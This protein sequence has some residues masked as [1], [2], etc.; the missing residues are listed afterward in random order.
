MDL[1]DLRIFRA[2]GESGSFT[3][4]AQ[5]LY[6]AQP[7]VSHRMAELEAEVGV[8]LFARGGRGTHLTPAGSLLMRHVCDGLD[9]IDR[10]QEALGQYVAGK[11]G[12]VTL[13]SATTAATY[14]LPAIL[15]RYLREHPAID[16]KV[17]TGRSREVLGLMSERQVDIALVRREVEMDGTVGEIVRSEPL[18]LVAAHGHRLTR[19]AEISPTDLR[20]QPLL[21]Y[22]RRS[23]FWAGAYAALS[24]QGASMHSAM[25][26]DSIEAVKAMCQAGLGLALLPQST[27]QQDLASGV[28]AAVPLA[29]V[30]LPERVTWLLR[31][32][33]TP[34]VGPLQEI[35][36]LLRGLPG[37]LAPR[38]TRPAPQLSD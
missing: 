1:I 28:L 17:R 2:V 4:A 33:D 14:M 38:G 32:E 21:L 6:L 36:D 29:G 35:W 22:H 7:T 20:G 18:L 26:L 34:L 13:G 37:S 10:G 12:A 30:Q 3:R 23:D 11:T 25:E 9:N 8:Q 16:L 19:R 5:I 27:V 31:R 24:Q 15:G